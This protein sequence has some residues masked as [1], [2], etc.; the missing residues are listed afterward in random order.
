MTSRQVTVENRVV[1]SLQHCAIG[2]RRRAPLICY[3]FVRAHSIKI[4]QNNTSS[5][6]EADYLAGSCR[7]CLLCSQSQQLHNMTHARRTQGKP[8][9]H[10]YTH[11]K[12]K[13]SPKPRTPVC[14]NDRLQRI[15][16]YCTFVHDKHKTAA[17]LLM[18]HKKSRGHCQ[19]P[20][21]TRAHLAVQLLR[22]LRTLQ[23]FTNLPTFAELAGW[24]AKLSC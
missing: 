3:F 15:V 21:T 4:L 16:S 5:F 8:Y 12:L 22:H 2:S 17:H 10:T 14:P 18:A 24:L 11:T 1:A 9:R 6:I 13:Q 20:V 23:G 19:S 7:E